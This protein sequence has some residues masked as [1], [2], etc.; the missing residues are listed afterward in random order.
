MMIAWT[1]FAVLIVSAVLCLYF[2]VK[3]AGP[4]ALEQ[5]IGPAA[6]PKCTRYRMLA[7]IFMTIAGINY[8]VYY[9]YPLP[10]PLPRTFPWPWWVSAL[11]AVVIAV[12]AG[13]LWVRGM[14]DAGEETMFVKKEHGLYGGIYEKIRHPQAV[15]ELP[16]WWVIAFLLHSPFL[17]L[18]SFIWVPIFAIMCWAEEQDLV[19]RYGEAYEAYR[20]R[21]GAFIPK[22]G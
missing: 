3:S 16:Y 13:Y 21:T 4:A 18:F 20:Q 11:I 9:F 14:K 12:P 6:Y 15:G 22:R 5:K 7:S 8:V 19:L 17:V 10:I 2:Y 1:N